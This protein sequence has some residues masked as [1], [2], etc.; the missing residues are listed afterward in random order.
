MSL[1]QNDVAYREGTI[2]HVLLRNCICD[3]GQNGPA[4]NE[5]IK[6]DG[7]TSEKFSAVDELIVQLSVVLEA[8]QQMCKNLVSAEKIVNTHPTDKSPRSRLYDTSKAS[9]VHHKITHPQANLHPNVAHFYG[10]SYPSYSAHVQYHSH[11]TSI[12]H[13]Q[14]NYSTHKANSYNGV[15]YHSITKNAAIC[16]QYIEFAMN[17]E[18]H[19]LNTPLS[20]Q[21]NRYQISHNAILDAM[22]QVQYGHLNSINHNYVQKINHHIVYQPAANAP[23]INNRIIVHNP[24]D[25]GKNRE[26]LS[27][28]M[29]KCKRQSMAKID[30]SEDVSTSTLSISCC[31]DGLNPAPIPI[32]PLEE[33]SQQ[34]TSLQRELAWLIEETALLIPSIPKE[35][36]QMLF[37]IAWLFGSLKLRQ[38]LFQNHPSLAAKK[39]DDPTRNRFAV[40]DANQL[41]LFDTG[42]IKFFRHLRRE[43][44]EGLNLGFRR[45]DSLGKLIN[46]VRRFRLRKALEERGD[47]NDQSFDA[48]AT[49]KLRRKQR[50][51][52]KKVD[53]CSNISVLSSAELEKIAL[54]KPIVL[55]DVEE[56]I[57]WLCE[58]SLLLIPEF[59]A[60]QCLISAGLVTKA[61]DVDWNYVAKYASQTLR[62]EF[63][64]T[65]GTISN[66]TLQRVVR[67][68][69]IHVRVAFKKRREIIANLITIGHYRRNETRDVLPSQNMLIQTGYIDILK[70]KLM[71]RMQQSCKTHELASDQDL[72]AACNRRLSDGVSSSEKS[73]SN[74]KKRKQLQKST[75]LS[76]HLQSSTRKCT[77]TSPL[78]ECGNKMLSVKQQDRKSSILTQNE[79][80]LAWLRVEYE[81]ETG[82]KGYDWEYI[83]KFASKRLKELMME[84]KVLFSIFPTIPGISKLKAIIRLDDADVYS[85]FRVKCRDVRWAINNGY[86]RD[87]RKDTPPNIPSAPPRTAGAYVEDVEC[88]FDRSEHLM[89]NKGIRYAASPEERPIKEFKRYASVFGD[90]DL[91]IELTCFV[92]QE[93]VGAS[94]KNSTINDSNTASVLNSTKK[95]LSSTQMTQAV[96]VHGVNISQG[97]NDSQDGC[98]KSSDTGDQQCANTNPYSE[99]CSLSTG[100]EAADDTLMDSEDEE[101][102]I[103]DS[104]GDESSL[105][106]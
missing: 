74:F 36:N 81:F 83:E 68:S 20:Y 30:K 47:N 4:V 39:L 38:L 77:H 29:S 105:E 70:A 9:T 67:M 6:I 1:P 90:R 13:P 12:S 79:E 100:R 3:D 17:K 52:A 102:L 2:R 87:L 103:E 58:E 24:F 33:L 44:R 43:A 72:R 50:R 66:R 8:D 65:R 95:K 86:R 91:G 62:V 51:R 25:H 101:F 88:E 48:L 16:N 21:N 99:E 46:N 26:F 56:E 85:A 80:E 78:L 19:N 35:K 28:A 23:S 97:L 37:D 104:D 31:H 73:P 5:N 10:P 82:V 40:I 49:G 92:D 42:D 55:S 18:L 71:R 34:P 60:Q 69:N 7:A 98:L 41:L 94:S 45:S 57:A 53:Q 84:R 61:P 89:Q 27:Q 106:M 14:H 15:N 96:G 93:I 63:Q 75:S 32:N 64:R 76:S 59:S 11:P 22:G 54:D